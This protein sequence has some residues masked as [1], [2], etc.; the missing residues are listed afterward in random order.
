[1]P[2]DPLIGLVGVSI[3]EVNVQRRGK[4]DDETETFIRQEHDIE[5]V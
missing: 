5:Q 3:L 1:M 4:A 2:R